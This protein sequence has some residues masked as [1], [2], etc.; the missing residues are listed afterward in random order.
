MEQLKEIAPSA[1]P[2]LRR[3]LGRLLACRDAEALAAALAAEFVGRF[4]E[5]QGLLAVCPAETRDWLVWTLPDLTQ[6]LWP[7]SHP[8]VE[9][10]R[11]ETEGKLL[12]L[13]GLSLGGELLGLALRDGRRSLLG[14]LAFV[15]PGSPRRE[16]SE[17]R[18]REDWLAEIGPIAALLLE[19]RAQAER[20][21]ALEQEV[22]ELESL[23]A[24]F[25]DTVTHELRTP[26]TSILGF[27]SLALDQ[28]GLEL[29]APLS[30][31]LRSIHDSALQLDRLIS[32]VLVMSEMASAEG[33]LELEDR[34]L[35]S[36][37]TEYREG[38]LSRLD[39]NER[40][41]FPE[42]A[43]QCTIRVDPYQ[44]HR[45][46][47]HLLKN[48]LSFSPPESPV[49][50]G[51]SF[52][53]GRR[54]SDSTDFLRID[55]SDRGPGIPAVEQERIFRKFYQVDRSST[56]EHGGAGLGLTVAKEFTEAMGGRL[57]LRSEAGRGSTFS[58]TVPVP[59]DSGL[60][61]R[62]PPAGSKQ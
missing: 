61:P 30:E 14:A 35:G 15:L 26:L 55:I 33:V 18:A 25:V 41:R 53:A 51:C 5:E 48:A 22:D 38:W 10:L 36:L 50:V 7:A 6:E 31:F 39:G 1:L 40:V 19:R 45:I 17:R 16:P 3:D 54:R 29:L 24:G 60:A 46:L 47:G 20:L 59:R 4:P 49:D 37:F 34:S 11:E 2:E 52:V 43:L 32:E 9:E 8:I 23:K 62:R 21:E 42:D 57:W 44:F 56:R 12:A 27:S 58:F 28:P 13:E